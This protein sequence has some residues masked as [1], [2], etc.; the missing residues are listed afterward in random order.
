[1]VGID[2]VSYFGNHG[3]ERWEHGCV[4]LLPEVAGFAGQMARLASSLEQGVGSLEGVSV[5]D[6]GATLSVHYRRAPDAEA[7]RQAILGLVAA[8]GE[9]RGL[10]CREGKM[11]VEVRPPVDVDKGGALR[12]AVQRWH[13]RSVLVFGDDR[14]GCGCLSGSSRTSAR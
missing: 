12:T 2:A 4:T 11:V 9:A 7:A 3:L 6:K 1:M 10:R 8:C 5:E 14:D 13:L